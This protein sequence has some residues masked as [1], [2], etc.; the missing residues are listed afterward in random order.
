MKRLLAVLFAAMM[1][2]AACGD[3]SGGAGDPGSIDDCD[4][5]VGAGLEMLQDVLDEL[6]E[7]S[8]EDVAALGDEPPEALNDLEARGQELEDRA[9]ELGCTDEELSAGLTARVDEL[10]ADGPFA[11]LILEGI[12]TEGFDFG[13]E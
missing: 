3:S 6:G 1:V 13:E 7:L 2:L 9:D 8:F 10:E 5:L 11:E 4:D 12:Q